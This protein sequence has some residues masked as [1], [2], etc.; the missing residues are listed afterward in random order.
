MEFEYTDTFYV[1]EHDL[2]K[3]VDKV[4]DGLNV[5]EVIDDWTYGLDDCDYYTV[6]NI[7]DQLKE[8]IMQRVKEREVK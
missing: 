2:E 7:R 3:F 1:S 6:N 4:I 5:D 8:E